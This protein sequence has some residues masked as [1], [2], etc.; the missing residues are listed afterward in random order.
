VIVRRVETIG[1]HKIF[2][3]ALRSLVEIN[4]MCILILVVFELIIELIVFIGALV[5]TSDIRG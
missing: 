3:V 1:I 2:E 4:V 5:C